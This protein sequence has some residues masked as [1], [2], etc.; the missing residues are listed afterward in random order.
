[1]IPHRLTSAVTLAFL[2]LLPFLAVEACGPFFEPDTFVRVDRPD[3]PQKF[4]QGQLGI[5]QQRFD[6]TDLAVAFRYLNGGKLSEKEQIAYA[7]PQQ[8]SQDWS[9]MTPERIAAAREMEINQ[10][11]SLQ[12]QVAHA[13]YTGR[14][15]QE[16]QQ[17]IL[18]QYFGYDSTY[19]NPDYLNC[20]DAAFKTAVLTINS[21][22]TTWGAQNPY[23][24]DWITA[25]DA[26]FS[27]CSG[28]SPAMPAA[29]PAGS[30]A[31]LQADRAYQM[32]AANFYSGKYDE[33]SKQFE[34]IAQDKTSPWHAWGEYLAAR[35]LVRLAF[36]QGKKTD[37][38]SGEPAT[39]DLQ[40]M[41]AAQ[42]KLEAL[43]NHHDS[44]LSRE[45]I[46]G[47][48]NFVRIRTEPD[49]R[50][51]EI[52]AAL[53]GPAPDP[54]FRQDLD[55]LNYVFY[56]KVKVDNPPLYAWITAFRTATTA[57]FAFA[58]WQ[59]SHS[60]PW[61]V[62]ALTAAGPKESSVPDLLTAASHI[63]ASSPAFDTIT[64]H[65]VRLLAALGHAD[66]ARGILDKILPVLRKQQPSSAL[67]AFLSERMQVARNFDEFLT[68]APRTLLD[69]NSQGAMAFLDAHASK[70]GP[71]AQPPSL[72]FAEDSTVVF[73]RQMPLQRLVE[74]A[75]SDIL[76]PNLR[77]DVTLAAWTRSVVLEDKASAAALVPHLP[78][79]IRKTAGD[80]IGFPAVLAILRNPGLRPYVESGVSRLASYS[81]LESYRDNWW[82]GGLQQEYSG[83]PPKPRVPAPVTFLS[84][85][86]QKTAEAEYQR[87]RQRPC[88]PADLGQRVIDYAKAYPSDP[89]VPEALA[90]TVRATHYG[91]ST[92]GDDYEA[93]TKQNSAVSKAAFQLLHKSYPKSPWAAKT[94]YYY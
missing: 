15:V 54:N 51:A 86:Q 17:K 53:A 56:K 4:A 24:K 40:T 20:P 39:F 87:L 94:P 80:G 58:L 30:P 9:K 36:S 91:A 74:A 16:T 67:N 62:A 81:Y 35:A 73:N 23:L 34:A 7:P 37:P 78:E 52:S 93:R 38:W 83:N 28:K 64:F 72:Q 61:L 82:C 75:T 6:S 13:K 29:A 8:Q 2:L 46:L 32:A 57:D 79:S 66:E 31:L 55:D 50:L 49:K 25:Q 45:T 14:N 92:Y 48:L 3:D 18:E 5:L 11:P 88:A 69:K 22:A 89:D 71:T 47:E 85:D 84:D 12:W 27:N 1:M 10:H 65:R 43:L 90:L 70:Q 19:Y 77:Q 21:R 42:Q 63:E 41:Q 44:A 68:Y 60:L 59:Q 33:A 76:P 26:V